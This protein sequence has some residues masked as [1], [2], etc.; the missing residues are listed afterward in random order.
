MVLSHQ[1]AK[2]QQPTSLDLTAPAPP[3]AIPWPAFLPASHLT[4]SWGLCNPITH[5]C[6]WSG[7]PLQILLYLGCLWVPGFSSAGRF[8]RIL[9]QKT[10]WCSTWLRQQWKSEARCG[11]W[12]APLLLMPQEVLLLH[13]LLN[14]PVIQ[15]AANWIC[16]LREDLRPRVHTVLRDIAAGNFNSV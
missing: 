16:R 15:P 6:F 8:W 7:S 2:M 14:P 4:Q 13:H 3:E 5:P 10:G 1:S 11:G 9:T 12:G